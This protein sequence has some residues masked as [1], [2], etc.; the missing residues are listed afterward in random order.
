MALKKINL[1]DNPLHL[2]KEEYDCVWL[3]FLERK[4]AI[5]IQSKAIQQIDWLM[6]N[7]ISHFILNEKFRNKNQTTF[8]PTMNKISSN[9]LAIEPNGPFNWQKFQKNCEGVFLKKILFFCE[10]KKLVDELEDEIVKNK[11]KSNHIT[12]GYDH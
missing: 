4:K 6:N 7:Q 12:I 2:I 10:D 3:W 1:K 5:P 11:V 9:F 8:I